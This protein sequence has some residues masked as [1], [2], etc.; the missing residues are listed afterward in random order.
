MTSTVDTTPPPPPAEALRA[1]AEL[2]LALDDGVVTDELPAPPHGDPL[3]MLHEL[4]VHQ[5]ELE[6]QNEEL[7]RA[8]IE[9]EH[10]RARYFD[11]FDLA[12]VGYLT[13]SEMGLILEANFVASKLLGLPRGALVGKRFSAFIAVPDQ[14]AY[15]LFRKAV[16]ERDILHTCTLRMVAHEG[17]TFWAN[18]DAIEAKRDGQSPVVRVTLTDS[19]AHVSAREAL[20]TLNL[21]LE[22]SNS[23]LEQFAY[24]ASHDLLEPLR[25]VSGSVQLLQ[26]RYG[27]QLDATADTFIHHA[28]DGSKR[29]QAMIMDLLAYSRVRADGEDNQPVSMKL[30]FDLACG[31]LGEAIVQS[32]AHITC[33]ALP[34][35]QGHQGQLTQLFQN[36]VGNALK[37]NGGK[38]AVVEVE[39]QQQAKGWLFSVKDHG[40]G[41]EAQYLERIFKLFQR[42]HTREEYTGTG[43]GLTL[44]KK[45]VERHGGTIWVESVPGV[46]TT[47]FF[48]LPA[49]TP[50]I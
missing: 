44:C 49:L 26:K 36:L 40:I 13:L 6:M 50:K 35:L 18:L 16:L 3:L 1:Q 2:L 31:N 15:Y 34:T 45:I 8:Q 46:G 29:M 19:S 22:R 17:G 39:A 43:I 33:G 30:A 28:V 24:A 12:P 5:I 14:D 4:R 42:L 38:P 21:E 37:F 23:D 10:S 7:R 9:L 27:G 32:A 41:I 47:V 48:T 20:Q 25:S 11:L